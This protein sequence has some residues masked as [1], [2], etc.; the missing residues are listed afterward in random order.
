MLRPT[1]GTMSFFMELIEWG[2]AEGK[3]CTQ[4]LLCLLPWEIVLYNV[5]SQGILGRR[6]GYILHFLHD[7]YY[8]A[9]FLGNW[10]KFAVLAKAFGVVA[11]YL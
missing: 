11:S 4:A 2:N 5:K 1:L 3:W 10:V 6:K 7:H 8:S 9:T